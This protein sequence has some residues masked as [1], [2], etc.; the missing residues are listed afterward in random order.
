MV[1]E[2]KLNSRKYATSTIMEKVMFM[3]SISGL[4]SIY[5]VRSVLANSQNRPQLQ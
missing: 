5:W 3:P 4:P 2:R 1:Q